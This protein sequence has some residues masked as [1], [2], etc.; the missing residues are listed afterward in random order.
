MNGVPD[1]AEDRNGD[2]VVD[3]LDCQGAQG[4]QGPQGPPGNGTVMSRRLQV[5]GQ[6]LNAGCTPYAGAE[7]TITVPQAGVVIFTS[8]VHVIISHTMGT[9]DEFIL[10]GGTSPMDCTLPGGIWNVPSAL[11]SASY[12]TTVVFQRDFL[13]GSAGTYTFY[14]NSWIT[15]GAS[16]GDI[17]ERSFTTV[18]FYP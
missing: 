12:E 13:V 10:Y 15:S 17:I 18:V 2:M 3:V 5:A 6:Q 9:L 14:L 1:P 16:M 8:T 4:P 11:P 7:V